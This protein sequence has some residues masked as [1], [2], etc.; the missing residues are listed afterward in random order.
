MAG[1]SCFLSS[2]EL[3]FLFYLACQKL[4][5]ILNQSLRWPTYFLPSFSLARGLK[6]VQPEAF[7]WWSINKL[8]Q[9]ASFVA[10]WSATTRLCVAQN[11][12]LS[13][14]LEASTCVSSNW[15]QTHNNE[16]GSERFVMIIIQTSGGWSWLGE[17]KLAFQ[18]RTL[19][20][21]SFILILPCFRD[22]ILWARMAL[23]RP[24]AR[25]KRCVNNKRFCLEF[26]SNF[27]GQ[28]ADWTARRRGPILTR[29]LL[30]SGPHLVAQQPL[31][32]DC[33][34]VLKTVFA[35]DPYWLVSRMTSAKLH[36]ASSRSGNNIATSTYEHCSRTLLDWTKKR[37]LETFA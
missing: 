28:W 36:L 1:T 9:T 18:M 16:E 4:K 15:T 20:F 31:A 27:S 12:P 29:F 13:S 7:C 14:R 2:L 26:G 34:F 22:Q 3:P 5:L 37:K 19:F 23:I 11:S 10:V 30:I 8:T 24:R 21:L 35:F 25:L 6:H 32:S 17:L 33:C